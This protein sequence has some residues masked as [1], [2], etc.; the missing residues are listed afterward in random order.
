MQGFTTGR[1]AFVTLLVAL[2]TASPAAACQSTCAE[3]LRACK[4]TCASGG[5][6]RQDCRAACAER[7]NCTAP[8]APIHTLAYV[9]AECRAGAQGLSSEQKL[10]IRRG[11]CDPVTVPL[12]PLSVSGTCIGGDDPS[13][14]VFQRIAVLP[15]GSGVVF[16]VTN[17][18]SLSPAIRNEELP[19]KGMF[20][21]RADGRGLRRL[22]DAS[23]SY[24]QTPN[25]IPSRSELYVVA[26][27]P[28]GRTLA[29]SDLGP[30]PDGRE[31]DQIFALDIATGSRRQLTKRQA[32]TDALQPR[33]SCLA[34]LDDR[35]ITFCSRVF[36][37]HPGY[38]P[39]WLFT[40]I[41]TVQ[42]DGK[43]PA[44]EV[45]TVA[46]P[47]GAI[48]PQFQVTG[49]RTRVAVTAVTY[50]AE[51][52]DHF[53]IHPPV[54]A[55]L[56]LLEG[57]NV[58]QLTAFHRGDTARSGRGGAFVGNRVFF[59]ASAD[60]F[61]TNPDQYCQMFS[62]NTL[63]TGL[64]QVTHLRDRDS[65]SGS[66]CYDW[67]PGSCS[68]NRYFADRR[69]GTIVFTSN[70]DP[71]G[72]NPTADEQVFSMRPDGAGLRQLTRADGQTIPFDGAVS[73]AVG[74]FAYQ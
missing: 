71:V 26:V 13:V 54:F 40:A 44:R 73:V 49:T 28:D 27:S 14:G 2:G 35:T 30:G 65:P 60:P 10:L 68:I 25:G 53:A 56:Y 51:P 63:G 20:F 3:G 66:G 52:A 70:C 57:P 69:S 7:S 55:E 33:L 34:F 31:T 74:P 16:E 15:D 11:N 45:A 6:A 5:Q 50:P 41:F 61:G 36:T 48:V 58:V 17:E 4:R 12:F 43:R 59:D 32:A 29:F 22:G 9:A 67:S 64:R 18:F 23:H 46:L 24:T 1:F 19:A 72:E 8:G 47:G 37:L 21:V 38:A 62:V 39:V 42:T